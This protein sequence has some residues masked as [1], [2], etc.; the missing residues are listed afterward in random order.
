M[1]CGMDRRLYLAGYDVASPRRLRASLHLIKG[2]ATGGQKSLY[3]CFLTE[4]E[5]S[6]L[7]HDMAMVLEEEED[8]FLL[9]GI[10]PRS[11]VYTLGM[12]DAPIDP[13][14]FYIA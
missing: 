6:R 14:Y 11:R 10:D 3:E 2:H 7:V 5:K 1:G 8:K 13:S 9:I 12:A 4:G